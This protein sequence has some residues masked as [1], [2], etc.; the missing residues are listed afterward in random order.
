MDDSYVVGKPFE[1][2]LIAHLPRLRRYA[3][4]MTGSWS[5]ADDVVQLTVIRAIEWRD[6]YRGGRF[7][8]WLFSIMRSVWSNQIKRRRQ[9]QPFDDRVVS[10]IDGR[11]L[12]TMSDRFVLRD[13]DRILASFPTEWRELVLL[14]CAYGYTYQEAAD[15]LDLNIGTVMSR[16]N[17][18]RAY[19]SK[20]MRVQEESGRA[21][22]HG[23]H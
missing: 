12:E 20:E 19:I 3:L 5:D 9:E 14:V 8:A 2:K 22:I 10:I 1:Q 21:S 6:R 13:V 17:R 4:V 15:L 11:A 7:E 16:L 23:Q 18:V